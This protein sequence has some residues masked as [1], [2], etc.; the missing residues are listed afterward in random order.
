MGIRLAEVMR[1]NHFNRERRI[2]MLYSVVYLL[3][4]GSDLGL[5]IYGLTLTNDPESFIRFNNEDWAYVN[6]T[7]SGGLIA[8]IMII[9]MRFVL[10]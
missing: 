6:M 8:W 4:L 10:T 7:S 2:I 5:I 3:W 9:Y 1:E